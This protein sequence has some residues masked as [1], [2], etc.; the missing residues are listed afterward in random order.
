MTQPPPPPPRLGPR[1]LA[2][3]LILQVLTWGGW[4]CGL[5]PWNGGWLSL[6][7]R[8]AA[9]WPAAD[10]LASLK[11]DPGALTAFLAAA[12]GEARRHL[13]AFLRGVEAYHAHPYHRPLVDPPPCWS[14][15]TTLLRD[16]GGFRGAAPIVLIPSLVNRAQ[17]LDLAPGRSLCRFLVEAGYRPFLVDWDQPGEEEA[18][19]DIGA[20]VSQ[21][22]EPALAAVV[23]RTGV[24]PVVLGYCMGG[25]LALA[26]AS[27]QPGLVRGLALLATPFDFA[28]GDD[29][30][31]DLT[32]AF[33][34]LANIRRARNRPLPVDLVQLPFALL[35][36]LAISAKFE[37][38]AR[39]DPAS[40]RAR[41]FVAVE[42]WLNDGIA[43]AAPVAAEVARVWYG[44]NAPAQGTWWVAGTPVIAGALE[45][46]SLV[47][48][49]ARDRIV[50]AESAS[51]LARALPSATVLDLALG[52][53]GMVAGRQAEA[54]LYG[55]LVHWLDGL[56]GR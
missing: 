19:F 22:L 27:R 13:D 44:D 33:A 24:R 35:D 23:E 43:L 40:P 46:P 42:D 16:Y 36:P 10:L 1:P 49:P 4:P 26:L 12:D 29:A 9:C 17:I 21:R 8:S 14:A 54:R 55:P 20:Y 37:A 47:V 28:A 18:G 7:E 15:G 25:L 6:K 48:L 52:H 34:P 51:A 39:L 3:H 38:F 45:T 56:A 2:L 11:G 30:L 53:V 5:M 50:P 41:D 32:R 31:A